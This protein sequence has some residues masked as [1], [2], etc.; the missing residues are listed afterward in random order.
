M[1]I[2]IEKEIEDDIY[3]I[4][5]EID[6]KIKEICTINNWVDLLFTWKRNTF[7]KEYLKKNEKSTFIEAIKYEYGIYNHKLDIKK[8]YELYKESADNSFD[9]LSM[10]RLF[11]IYFMDYKKFK[12]KRNR[13]FEKFYLYKCFVYLPYKCIENCYIIL[14][15]INIAEIISLGLELEDPDFEK[16]NKL[17]KYL[18][19]N[20]IFDRNQ[21]LMV[22]SI[23]PYIF[24]I[25]EKENSFSKLYELY[26]YFQINEV[27]NKMYYLEEK[28][29]FKASLNTFHS[30]LENEIIY[31]LA[32]FEKNKNN[33]KILFEKL[34]QN[35]YYRSYEDYALLL[36]N[37]FNELKKAIIILEEAINNGAECYLTYYNLLLYNIFIK[38]YETNEKIG[39]QLI[40]LLNILIKEII[41]GNFF[42]ISEFIKLRS[43]IIK[44]FN[45]ENEINKKYKQITEDLI[46]SLIYLNNEENTNLLK[47]NFDKDIIFVLKVCFASLYYYGFSDIIKKNIEKSY[48]IFKKFFDIENLED[49]QKFAIKFYYKIVR[50]VSDK[51]TIDKTS[52]LLFN[53]FSNNFYEQIEPLYY[54]YYFLGKSYEK[55]IGIKKDDILSFIFYYE[56]SKIIYKIEFGTFGIKEFFKIF[57]L[58]KKLE[59]TKYKNIKKS[60]HSLI[61]NK[62]DNICCVCYDRKNDHFIIP[63]KHKFCKVCIKKIENNC[64]LCRGDIY[65]KLNLNNLK[66]FF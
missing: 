38:G 19:K 23:I 45:L 61:D 34:Y 29:N 5:E 7:L 2:K 36:I 22:K 44:Y 17:C 35:K 60:F 28:K 57:K 25:E 66:T 18:I 27:K 59:S 20:M 58:K 50:N 41:S 21:I 62:E 53:Y 10:Y 39:N 13:I 32:C 49:S 37:E 43:H 52:K 63:C 46:N 6:N 47:N 30:I 33:S 4:N 12:L 51:N 26:T 40:Y 24:S 56:G 48:F 31:K 65:F 14:N 8:S 15:K 9:Y 16:F 64:P 3:P 54:Y 55:G 42:L 11:L 1:Y